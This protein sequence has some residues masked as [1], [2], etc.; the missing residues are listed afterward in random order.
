MSLQAWKI[1]RVV[2]V[3]KDIDFSKKQVEEK[4]R[5]C[6]YKILAS[7]RYGDTVG[8]FSLSGA[9]WCLAASFLIPR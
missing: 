5:W 9:S 3:G 8:H 7:Q 6:I 2:D 1:L 4:Q